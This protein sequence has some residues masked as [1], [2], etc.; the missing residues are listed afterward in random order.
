MIG[1]T[2]NNIKR[3]ITHRTH[4]HKQGF[5]TRLMS[6]GDFGH[7]V[8]PFVF[9]D[10]FETSSFYGRGLRA[11]PHSGIA[12]HTTLIEGSLYYEDSTGKSGVLKSGDLEW[13][14]AGNAVWHGGEP[15]EGK[16]MRGYQLW[17]SLPQELELAPAESHYINSEFVEGDDKIKLLLG[18]YG[19]L[20]SSIKLPVS[21]TYLYVKLRDGERWTYYPSLDHETAWLAVN[22]G[23]I[24]TNEIVLENEMVI[25]SEGNSSI[26]FLSYGETEFVIGSGAKHPYPLVTGYYSVHTSREALIKGELNI[27]KLGNTPE[28]MAMRRK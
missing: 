8:K 21:I 14:Q 15:I 4:G 11:H 27:E 28:V 19:K 2:V 12:T 25:F 22:R 24:Q 5:I 18:S 3:S 17:I 10:Y 26:E 9:L 13:M 7:L 1:T 16:G 23:K 6:P 20:R